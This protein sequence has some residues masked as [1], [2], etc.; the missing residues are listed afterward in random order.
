MT[1]AR[2]VSDVLSEHVQ[3]EVDCID[4]MYLNVYVP[5]LQYAA[6]L[7]GYV[8]RRLGLPVAS[9]APL[10]RITDQFSAAVRHF[11][12]DNAVPWVDF[13]KGQRKDDV[14]QEYLAEFTGDEGVL[15]IGGSLAQAD[16]QQQQAAV[17]RIDNRVDPLRQHGGAAAEPGGHEFGRGDNQIRDQRRIDRSLRACLHAYPNSSATGCPRSVMG[18]GRL[19]E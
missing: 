2:S 11:A 10:A 5:Q 7:V 1:V 19:P 3:F 6:G 18:T 15:F 16:S 9:T 14:A 13:A 12:R 4:R 17:A 8:H